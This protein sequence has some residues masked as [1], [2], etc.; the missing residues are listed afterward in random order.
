MLDSLVFSLNA[1]LPLMLLVAIGYLLKKVKLIGEGFAK[2]ANKLVFK[3]FLPSMLFLNVYSIDFGR[4]E[5]SAY[6]ILYA[7]IAVLIVFALALLTVPRV[8][9]QKNRYAPLMQ[10][11]F[12]SNYALIGVPLAEA[13][14]GSEGAAIASLMVAFLIPLYNILAVTLFSIYSEEGEKPSIKK[15]VI[16][17]LKNPLIISALAGAVFL[18][19]KNLLFKVGVD[20]TLEDIVPIYKTLTYL[21]NLATPLALLVLGAQFEFSA[22]RSLR[23]EIVYGV[24][25]RVLIVPTVAILGAHL[26]G[27]FT[28]A[29]MACF[30]G[31]FATPIAVST[32]PMAQEL[33]GDTELAGQLVVWTTL[34]SAITIFA[35]TVFF[36]SVG[37]F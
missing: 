7:M 2:N 32:V 21:K 8:T 17:I 37:V 31:V 10:S 30:I 6:Y 16:G 20:T 11:A 33:G 13:I 1:V 9:K 36:R 27:I 25:A 23:R 3:V 18:L 28:P 26:L 35:F 12:R 5:V 22:V 24:L 14:G 15:T 19:L 34:F 4:V 29:Q